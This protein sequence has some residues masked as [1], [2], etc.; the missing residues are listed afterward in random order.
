MADI[1]TKTIARNAFTAFDPT[2]TTGDTTTGAA[3]Q[4][5][6][7]SG[8]KDEQVVILIKNTSATAG[9]DVK[10]TVTA[11]D[12][13]NSK[14]TALSAVV[15][16]GETAYLGPLDSMDYLQTS[17]D[18]KGKIVITAAKATTEGTGLAGDITLC[19]LVIA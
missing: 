6:P 10:V 5:V 18:N 2:A 13:P 7:M 16:D 9:D 12:H 19:A 11:G 4:T 3:S 1:A 17:G 14:G 15:G 8:I